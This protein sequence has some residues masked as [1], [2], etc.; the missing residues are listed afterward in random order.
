M[1]IIKQNK[2]AADPSEVK[3]NNS[4]VSTYVKKEEKTYVRRYAM[5]EGRRRLWLENHKNGQEDAIMFPSMKGINAEEATLEDRREKAKVLMICLGIALVL[6]LL[7]PMARFA[8]S[9]LIVEDVRIEGVTAYSGEEILDA[10]GLD[11]GDKLPLF[12]AKGMES[13]LRESL[14]Y[15]KN[16]EVTF[17]LPGTVIIT[18]TDESPAFCAE[19]FGE[20]YAISADLRVLERAD[21]SNSFADLIYIDLPQVSR[22]V[23]GETIEFADGDDCDHITEFFTLLAQ[24]ELDGRIDRV[25]FDKK[26]D[27]VACV[28]SE[29]R[30][31]FGSPSDMKLK[32][33]AV[34]RMVYDNAEKCETGGIVDVRVVEIAGIVINA[35]IDP[36]A[37]E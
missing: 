28:D 11:L 16:C 30:V 23:V 8:A 20:Y 13:S 5:S 34:A 26:F 19:I 35:G 7:W 18:L 22:A 25:Y 17:E 3:S 32:L 36:T 21:V 37:R 9:H 29:F 10:A 14:P 12:K 24:S 4:N 15:L 31:M 1:N 27:I 33:G 2:P 6:L